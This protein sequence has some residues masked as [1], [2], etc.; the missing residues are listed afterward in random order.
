M[1]FPAGLGRVARP[2]RGPSMRVSAPVLVSTAKLKPPIALA[3]LVVAMKPVPAN[4]TSILASVEERA[5]GHSC[6]LDSKAH[7]RA[8][9][10]WAYQEHRTGRAHGRFPEVLFEEIPVAPSARSAYV[11]IC[12]TPSTPFSRKRA[13]ARMPSLVQLASCMPGRVLLLMRASTRSC[14]RKL[15]TLPLCRSM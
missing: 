7:D 2:V 5:R 10:A 12:S 15:Y 4:C 6:H 14:T 9:A 11:S 13:K 3:L 1:K 8:A